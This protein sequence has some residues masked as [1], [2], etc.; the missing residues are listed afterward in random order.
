MNKKVK[1]K[2]N[3]NNLVE[4]AKAEKIANIIKFLRLSFSITLK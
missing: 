1:G 4:V 3:P 2:T